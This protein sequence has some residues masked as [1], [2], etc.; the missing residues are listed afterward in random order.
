M[1]GEFNRT[2]SPGSSASQ[3]KI[4]M[5]ST[6]YNWEGVFLRYLKGLCHGSPVHF[7]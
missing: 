5:I 1:V 3:Q 4:P 6:S 7:V 2:K